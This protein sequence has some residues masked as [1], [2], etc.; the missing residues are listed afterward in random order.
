MPTKAAS[1]KVGSA[2]RVKWMADKEVEPEDAPY[3]GRFFP[4]RVMLKREDGTFDVRY[5]DGDTEERV[6]LRNM[7]R[8]ETEGD[9]SAQA[10]KEAGTAASRRISLAH[11]HSPLSGR[12][13]AAHA[14][15]TWPTDVSL[16]PAAQMHRDIIR[17]H[18]SEALPVHVRDVLASGGTASD[19]MASGELAEINNT[20]GYATSRAASGRG[21]GRARKRER[22]EAARGGERSA[23][24]GEDNSQAP[25]KQP[26]E[27][28]AAAA[29]AMEEEEV[30]VEV[31]VEVEAP[32][33]ATAASDSE[34][35]V[36]ELDDDS[37]DV[38]P[39]LQRGR[40]E[41]DGAHK[42]DVTSVTGAYK[43]DV[44]ARATA[45]PAPPSGSPSHRARPWPPETRPPRPSERGHERTSYRGHEPPLAGDVPPRSNLSPEGKG[46]PPALRLR[47][48]T[49]KLALISRDLALDA[50]AL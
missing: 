1:L 45:A 20:E 15:P 21:E 38:A 32:A 24:D 7:Q 28:A 41:E 13:P 35:D 17:F 49:Q 47:P 5:D 30:E 22:G 6:V 42:A 27:A 12:L 16:A 50:G 9:L 2:V 4:G 11:L 8:L 39:S 25:A 46:G 40:G 36:I 18:G 19:G 44:A 37:S 34:E 26:R 43:E 33:G 3:K 23:A 29:T 31:E 14:R 48:S 10:R